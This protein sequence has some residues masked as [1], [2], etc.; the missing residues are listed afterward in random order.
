MG[1][2]LEATMRAV[3]EADAGNG[4]YLASQG[5]VEGGK[6]KRRLPAPIHRKKDKERSTRSVKKR[7]E[8]PVRKE[9]KEEVS[10]KEAEG[11][12]GSKW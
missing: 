6:G 12:G 7:K 4:R 11:K 9:G 3:A 10:G 1:D 5:T 8:A 2:F